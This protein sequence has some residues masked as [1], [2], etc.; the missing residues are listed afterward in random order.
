[1]TSL[2]YTVT[3]LVFQSDSSG[4]QNPP[5]PGGPGNVIHGPG[6]ELPIDD[7]IWVLVTLGILLGIYV[8]YKN[9]QSIDRVS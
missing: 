4:S 6:L 5:P 1:M 8:F 2:F 9:S 3:G 7:N